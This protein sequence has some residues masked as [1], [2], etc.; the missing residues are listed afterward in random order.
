MDNRLIINNLKKYNKF[1][2]KILIFLHPNKQ[3]K[4]IDF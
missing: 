3:R 2:K 4:Y 1:K